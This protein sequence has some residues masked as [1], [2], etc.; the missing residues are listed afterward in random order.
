MAKEKNVAG[1]S[2][3][4]QDLFTFGVYKRNQGRITR[5]VTAAVMMTIGID[6]SRDLTGD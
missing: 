2:S 4:M 3:F 1:F 5:Q 6:K